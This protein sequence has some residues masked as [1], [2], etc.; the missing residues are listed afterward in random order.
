MCAYPAVADC[1]RILSEHG[2]RALVLEMTRHVKHQIVQDEAL[3]A[4]LAHVRNDGT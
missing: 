2:P 3:L 1:A 4:L